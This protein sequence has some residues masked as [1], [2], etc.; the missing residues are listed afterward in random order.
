MEALAAK[1][2]VG[3]V[4]V[5]DGALGTAPTAAALQAATP[6]GKAAATRVASMAA[7]VC[8]GGARE[9]REQAQQRGERTSAQSSRRRQRWRRCRRRCCEASS[10][11]SLHA[12]R[13]L[14]RAATDLVHSFVLEY[15]QLALPATTLL[16][17]NMLWYCV[18]VTVL[19]PDVV[20]SVTGKPEVTGP[21]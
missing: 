13:C 2:V 12:L 8:G 5:K 16:S 17:R 4:P 21:A 7:L 3:G 1:I 18:V 14:P 19:V 6:V 9:V 10:R 15:P 11:V 20:T